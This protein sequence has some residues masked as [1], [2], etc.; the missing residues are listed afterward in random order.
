MPMHFL[1]IAGAPRRYAQ[2]TEFRYLEKLQPLQ[3]FITV[4]AFITIAAQCVFLYNFFVEHAQGQEGRRQPLGVHFAGM[5]H[6]VS[7]SP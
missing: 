6:F 3:L 4:A 2:L 5:G 1:G 7:A